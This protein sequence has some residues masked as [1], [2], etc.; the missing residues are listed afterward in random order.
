[1]KILTLIAASAFAM[2]MSGLSV[3]AE[4]QAGGQQ[5]QPSAAQQSGGGQSGQSSDQAGQSGQAGQNS[6]GSAEMQAAMKKCEQGPAADKQKCMDAA[7]K[8][9]GQM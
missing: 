2:S 6:Q 1:M 8:K 7:K 9:H 4:E 3:A 5:Q